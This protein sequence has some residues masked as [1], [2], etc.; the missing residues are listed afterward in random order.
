MKIVFG[1]NAFLY[2]APTQMEGILTI[3]KNK[4]QQNSFN[5][6]HDNLDIVTTQHFR[7]CVP[8]QK[9]LPS[10]TSDKCTYSM[11]LPWII[12]TLQCQH[13]LPYPNNTFWS[14][15]GLVLFYTLV[16]LQA[17]SRSHPLFDAIC[18][19]IVNSTAIVS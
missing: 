2:L 12:W 18:S 17:T 11:T 13:K 6:S 3:L 4:V 5:P 14:S 16:I 15:H 7:R 8:R 10:V 1:A 9:V 19:L